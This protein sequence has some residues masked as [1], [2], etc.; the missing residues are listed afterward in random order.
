MNHK[1]RI[2]RAIASSSATAFLVVFSLLPK[3]SSQTNKMKS[4]F[5]GTI[6][7]AATL[8]GVSNQNNIPQT[9]ITSYYEKLG[10]RV[11]LNPDSWCVYTALELMI[12]YYATWWDTNLLSE[13]IS[14][15]IVGDDGQIIVS[16]GICDGNNCNHSHPFMNYMVDQLGYIPIIN[17]NVDAFAGVENN[18]IPS[19]CQNVLDGY[20]SASMPLSEIPTVVAHSITNGYEELFQFLD[21][22][23]PVMVCLP[24]NPTGHAVTAFAHNGNTVYAHS[25]YAVG[26]ERGNPTLIE[27]S[28]VGI[29]PY[30]FTL[31]M[32]SEHE[33]S[34]Y[35]GNNYCPC[36]EAGHPHKGTHTIIRGNN[37]GT[38]GELCNGI[39]KKT[40]QCHYDRQQYD[41]LCHWH[42]CMCGGQEGNTSHFENPP[43]VLD[44]GYQH[45]LGCSDCDYTWTEDHFGFYYD[46]C[47]ATHYYSWCYCG[48]PFGIQNGTPDGLVHID[49]QSQ[50]IG[51]F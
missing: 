24:G 7:S 33:C 8:T 23:N 42:E 18:H 28:C 17:N 22:Q 13:D 25:G 19:H 9:Y 38:H 21:S 26:D 15:A 36:V 4:S 46:D 37:S 48:Y 14:P 34:D 11:L 31:E 50:I 49:D 12:S 32:H 20:L 10:E 5:V 35:Y 2:W 51:G 1:K 3:V 45:R 6:A 43:L 30:F 16:P 44:I 39:S 29:E 27:F 40:Y 47:D 41:E